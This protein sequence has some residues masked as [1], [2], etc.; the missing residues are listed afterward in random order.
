MYVMPLLR[1][2]RRV[3]PL[4]RLFKSRALSDHTVSRSKR[5][6]ARTPHM[7][8]HR[9]RERIGASRLPEEPTR[10]NELVMESDLDAHRGARSFVACW[11]LVT[12][13]LLQYALLG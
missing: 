12:S 11:L 4:R 13:R 8:A 7:G 9:E 1:R 2:L 10:P 3:R 5:L 6:A